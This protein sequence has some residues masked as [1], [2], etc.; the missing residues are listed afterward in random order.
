MAA[1]LSACDRTASQEGPSQRTAAAPP[2]VTAPPVVAAPASPRPDSGTKHSAPPTP[3]P[4]DLKPRAPDPTSS[5]SGIYTEQQAKEGFDVYLGSCNSCHAGLGNH[6]GPVF[7][8]NWGE[9]AVSDLFDYI[10]EYMPKNAPGSLSP[11]DNLRVIAYLLQ[12]N[13]M[14]AGKKPLPNDGGALRKLWIDTVVQK[15]R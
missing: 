3:K 13:G 15:T 1:M 12:V 6:T 9:R 10:T 7:R 5:Q 8:A 2:V 4:P 11:E 14:P